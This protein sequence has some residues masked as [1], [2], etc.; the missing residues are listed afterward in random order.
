MDEHNSA[1]SLVSSFLLFFLAEDHLLNFARPE[2]IT[3]KIRLSSYEIIGI[4][5][6]LARVS[7]YSIV[8][9]SRLPNGFPK[10]VSNSEP[11]IF[12]HNA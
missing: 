5:V 9:F 10:P 8:A 2:V 12:R 6:L 11:D 1:R 3:C 7:T 4:D